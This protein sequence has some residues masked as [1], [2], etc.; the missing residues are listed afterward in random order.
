MSETNSPDTSSNPQFTNALTP[1]LQDP[2]RC[3]G[4]T[5][6]L[7]LLLEAI[8][9]RSSLKTLFR[10]LTYLTL[11]ISIVLYV[12]T[13]SSIILGLS[14]SK[15]GPKTQK[16]QKYPNTPNNGGLIPAV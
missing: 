13:K 3:H 2:I 9:K 16:D 4:D 15:C 10:T 14:L 12:L 1:L 8:K 6:N 11:Q 5:G 7:S